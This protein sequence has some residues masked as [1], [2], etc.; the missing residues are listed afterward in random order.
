VSKVIYFSYPA[1]QDLD[2][3]HSDGGAISAGGE[4]PPKPVKLY[5]S[6]HLHIIAELL[7][8]TLG[9]SL[10][11]IDS[12]GEGCDPSQWPHTCP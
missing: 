2:Q 10:G 11:E 6:P 7:D 12:A 1:A 9:G 8:V 5:K 4:L 3:T